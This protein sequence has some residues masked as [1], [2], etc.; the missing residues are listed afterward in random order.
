MRSEH[1]GI[2]HGVHKKCLL[3]VTML[4]QTHIQNSL[5]LHGHTLHQYPTLYPSWRCSNHTNGHL[6]NHGSQDDR[7]YDWNNANWGTKW[8]T[9]A[10]CDHV[11]S[12]CFECEFETAWSPA[13]G[14]FY[15]LRE[16]YPDVQISWF[17]DEPGM[18]LAG[19]L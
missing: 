19:Y 18:E 11:E 14:I 16:Q 8:D 10:E 4:S 5:I 1:Q 7:W 12:N 6:V 2:A 3:L 17:Y 13:E 15:A 9:D